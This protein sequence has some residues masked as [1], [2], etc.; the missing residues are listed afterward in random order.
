MLYAF[1]Y[2]IRYA[3]MLY[4]VSWYRVL[5]HLSHDIMAVVAVKRV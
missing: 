4:Y 1:I 2:F 5:Q 3:F